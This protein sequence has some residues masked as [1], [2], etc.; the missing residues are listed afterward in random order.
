MDLP[1]IQTRADSLAMEVLEAYGGREAWESMRYLR[2][3]FGN[4]GAEGR[5]EVA[6]HLWDR[7]RNQYR[8]EWLQADSVLV[9]LFNTNTQEGDVYVN[10]VEAD[11][12][13]REDLLASGY[14]RFIN[15]TY[16]LLAPVK[17]LDP[18]VKRAYMA[19]S[20]NAEW[21]VIQLTFEDV[22][23]TPDDTFWFYVDRETGLVVR[24]SFVLQGNPDAPPA[25]WNWLEHRDFEVPGGTVRFSTRKELL[26]GSFAI[27]TDEIELPSNVADSMFASPRAILGSSGN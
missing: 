2:F 22:G 5:N 7:A 23:L 16:W 3:T 6:W 1:E 8:V 18:G 14:R 27:V 19:D 20:S 13:S 9:A 10:G 25:H 15:D 26:N 4:E 17:M 21:E 12:E 24:W 11:E